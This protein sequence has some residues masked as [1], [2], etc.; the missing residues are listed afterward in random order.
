MI[1][2]GEEGTEDRIMGTRGDDGEGRGSWG[3]DKGNG[4][5]RAGKGDDDGSV[6]IV[7]GEKEGWR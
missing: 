4:S 7:R 6:D 1:V 2:C 5:V 3:Y